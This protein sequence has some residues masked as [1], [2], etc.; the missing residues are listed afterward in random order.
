MQE[1]LYPQPLPTLLWHAT[2][3]SP[4]SWGAYITNAIEMKFCFG[5]SH[6]SKTPPCL[7]RDPR[8]IARALHGLGVSNAPVEAPTLQ[9]TPDG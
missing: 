3:L 2:L 6:V 1:A 8:T 5:I 9:Q 4:V 7:L